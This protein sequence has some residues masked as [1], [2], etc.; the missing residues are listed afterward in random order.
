MF[1][2]HVVQHVHWLCLPFE[3]MWLMLVTAS[4]SDTQCS[5]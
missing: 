5:L 1:P 4:V 2:Q 3:G